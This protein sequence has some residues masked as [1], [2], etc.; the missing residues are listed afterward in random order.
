MV[1]AMN[2]YHSI[3]RANNTMKMLGKQTPI[4]ATRSP[5]LKELEAAYTSEK[6]KR[7][8]FSRLAFSK[9]LELIIDVFNLGVIIGVRQERM[10]R[11]NKDRVYKEAQEVVGY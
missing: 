1:N 8:L 6:Y 3:Y 5:E 7:N 10:R 9:C 11:K 4:R 2:D